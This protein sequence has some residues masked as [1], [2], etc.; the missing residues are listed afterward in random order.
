MTGFDDIPESTFIIPALTTVHVH[1]QVMGELAAERVV[2]RVENED[3]IP[4]FIQT[5]THLVIRQSSGSKQGT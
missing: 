5:P 3:E 2:R 4:L 1:K